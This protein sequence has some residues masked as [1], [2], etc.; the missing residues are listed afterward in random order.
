M[1]KKTL[2][3]SNSVVV[4][5]KHFPQIFHWAEIIH[6]AC[7][8]KSIFIYVGRCNNESLSNKTLFQKHKIV[9]I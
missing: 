9:Y 1:E 2:E 3:I 7:T 5:D 8:Y 4:S 6:W